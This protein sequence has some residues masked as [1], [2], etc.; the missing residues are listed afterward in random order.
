MLGTIVNTGTVLLGSLIGLF[1]NQGIPERIANQMMKALGLCT[2]FIG[3]QG[4][5]KGEN[6]L[7]MIVSMVI[8]VVIG[9]GID[10]D[11]RV[12]NTV[13]RLE[14]KFVKKQDQKHSISEGLITSSLLFCVGSMT[15]VG[16]LNAG[17]LNDNTMLYTKAT[18]DFCS[19]MIF[20][21][22]LGIGVILAAGV[23]LIYQGGLTL[24]A[25]LAAPLLTT[26][27]INEMT[28]VGSLVIIATGLNL[29][30]VTKIK[31]MNY[32][33]AMFLPIILC[34]FM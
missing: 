12:T 11:K 26:A 1:L 30:G 24:L 23:V 5:F 20:A 29:L 8:G 34:L 15:I 18:L 2:I 19:S 25:S 32:I 6:T 14:E 27:V 13:N 16:C 22:T 21:S 3:V 33:P 10:I 4:A 28:C 9:E 17:L 31:L 7:I